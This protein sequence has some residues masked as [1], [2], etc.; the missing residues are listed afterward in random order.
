VRS[1]G[2]SVFPLLVAALLAA[3]T[4][5][6]NLATQSDDPGHRANGRHDPDFFVEHFTLR[7]FTTD[8]S[9]QHTVIADRMQHYPDDD[10]TAVTNPHLI[11]HTGRRT[12]ATSRT[13]LLDKDGKHVRLDD[14]VRI[15]R[16][17]NAEA[18]ETI[19]T[20]SILYVTPD[21]EYART[22][23]PVTIAQGRSVVHGVGMEAN[24][25]TETAV[26]SGPVQG[27]VYRNPDR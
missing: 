26:L 15:V 8:G 23:A 10:S 3:L 24:N 14:D 16:A 9:L 22:D 18:P 2:A 7:R 11:Y 4:W 19:I 13:A 25:K 27:T 20:T 5:W 21:D 1:V 17:G 6:L 12:V